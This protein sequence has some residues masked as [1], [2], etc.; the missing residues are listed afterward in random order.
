MPPASNTYAF[1]I[2]LYAQFYLT[3]CAFCS[4]RRE[5]FSLPVI[6]NATHP[7][8]GFLGLEG[9]QIVFCVPCSILSGQ[10][11]SATCC[12]FQARD[13]SVCLAVSSADRDPQQPMQ[14]VAA[15]SKELLAVSSADRDPQQQQPPALHFNGHIPCSI[16]SNQHANSDRRQQPRS[17]CRWRS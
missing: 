1:I 7:K 6:V 5:G 13:A 2:C 9:G 15:I 16:L 3:Y 8:G 4:P 10:R 11:S 12:E 14:T 17:I